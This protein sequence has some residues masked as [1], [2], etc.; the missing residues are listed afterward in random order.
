[1]KTIARLSAESKQVMNEILY[2][3]M[4]RMRGCG[5][6]YNVVLSLI[7][8]F[9]YLIKKGATI[10]DTVS[11]DYLV[12]NKILNTNDPLYDVVTNSLSTCYNYHIM[13]LMHEA[14]IRLA[15]ENIPDNEYLAYYDYAIECIS[16]YDKDSGLYTVP[17]GIA[18]LAD[19]FIAGNAG[20]VYIPFGGTM[21]FVTDLESFESVNAAYFYTGSWQVGMF[22]VALAGLQD[23]VN[24]SCEH[25]FKW[26]EDKYDTIISMPPFAVR[27]EVESSASDKGKG[28]HSDLIAPC[29]FLDNSSSNGICVAFAP[30]SIL[31]GGD[32]K[33]QFRTWAVKNK[34]LDTIILLPRHI[35]DGT[36]A[37]MACVVLRRKPYH[38]NA[39]RMIDASNMFA[40]E[41]HK[42]LL[43]VGDVMNA[44]HIDTKNVSRTVSYSEIADMDYSWN[45][46]EYLQTMEEACPDGYKIMTLN[47]IVELPQMAFS[48][49]QDG[50]KIIKVQDLSNDWTNPHIDVLALSETR[51]LRRYH[52]LCQDAILISSVRTLK[53]S[54]V[55]ASEDAPV[56]I[57]PNI[58]A[59]VPNPEIDT[60]FLCMELAKLNVQPMGA[61]TPHISKASILRKK[62]AYP[63]L[64]TQ[65]QLYKEACRVSMLSK[66]KELG[67]H[68][69]I[70]EMKAD[71]I[72]E[73]RVRKHDMKTPMA[74]MKA[75]LP[76]L[77]NLATTLPE[78]ASAKL[79][80]YVQR[81]K[82]AHDVLSEIVKHIADEDEFAAPEPVDIEEILKS[83]EMMTDRYRIEYHRD[84]VSL[85]EAGIDTPYI[86]MGRS[87][88]MRL[89]ENIV[90]NA[91]ERGFTKD[92]AEYALHISLSVDGDFFVIDFSNNGEPLPE[93]MDKVR[94]GTRGA[95]G[96]NST[97]SG[98][99]GYVVKSITQ[100][101]GGDY[102][103]MS[104]KFAGIWFTNVIVKL[105]IFRKED[106]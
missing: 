51:D 66:A 94:Y 96:V 10:K 38:E 63:D 2:M 98:T 86:Y 37:P 8:T 1:M 11:L 80:T 62:V 65:K 79:L 57:N 13:N 76:L 90:G 69:L 42:N 34:I 93:G 99:G 17:R 44:Y 64:T 103:I 49:P 59:V 35:L 52:R 5:I 85:S 54:I 101:Y 22:R 105:P 15:C 89:T 43:E 20:K 81:L 39:V 25:P 77:D 3:T 91:I 47:E 97:G 19:A 30:T 6:H 88:F 72:N 41:E 102:D 23:K 21:N 18:L 104:S 16:R 36:E 46:P 71:Y 74:Q 33:E 32:S 82:K 100:H 24:Y 95:K 68:K 106:E 31:W 48:S 84:K 58:V 29:R 14:F 45:I 87:D 26:H 56:W 28:E 70:D 4:D 83:H 40:N 78:E 9:L 53:P 27:I 75:T 92:G 61:T 60:E 67:L 12:E 7:G 50:G 55:S 73:V